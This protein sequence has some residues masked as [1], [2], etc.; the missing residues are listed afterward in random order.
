MN[1]ANIKL[2]ISFFL[3]LIL[4]VATLILFGYGVDDY[5]YYLDWIEIESLSEYVIY[6]KSFHASSLEKTYLYM[7]S[8]VKVFTDN[9]E[10]FKFY[11]TFIALSVL[12]FSYYKVSKTNYI[13]ML[14]FIVLYLFID[15]NIDQFRNALA[16]SFG[17]LA[18]VL[19]TEKKYIYSLGWFLI[20][21]LIHNSM[22]W[23]ILIYFVMFVKT[24]RLIV[25]SLIITILIPNKINFVSELLSFFSGVDVHF[26]AKISSYVDSSLKNETA[27]KLLSFVVVKAISIA[28]IGFYFKINRI[29]LY[30][31][32]YAVLLNF[33]FIDLHTIG[34]RILRDAFL[35]E[36]ILLLM[37]LRRSKNNV[38]FILFCFIVFLYNLSVK[39]ITHIGRMIELA[40]T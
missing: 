18:V 4:S 30:V 37:I 14:I 34:G 22:A 8:S 28:L 33:L 19:L 36:P 20:S 5:G 9:I 15:F 26:Y 12:T 3:I 31:Y 27:N 6:N 35:F 10:V 25:L 17:V 13:Y 29:Y 7:M 24:N 23:L 39:N 11:N 40:S 2:S 16:A 32:I 21:V 1:L 38:Y